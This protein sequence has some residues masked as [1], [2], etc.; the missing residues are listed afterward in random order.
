[1]AGLG[2]KEAMFYDVLEKST[3][4]CRLCYQLCTIP[5]GKRGLCGVR[6]NEGGRLYTLV[7][8]KAAATGLDPVE[9]KPLFHFHPGTS[10]YSI[11]TVGCNFRCRNCQNHDISQMPKNYGPIVGEDLQPEE[12]VKAAKRYE[13][14]SI[15][16]T[17]TE[18][19]VF[20][21]YAYE[22]ARLASE[23]GIRNIFVT[24]GYI[25][26]EAL[27]TIR[28]Y[29]DAANI[30][31]KSFSDEFYRES[32]GARL[33]PVLDNIKLHKELGIWIEITT[34]II[35][36]L[37]DSEE[38]L[39]KIARFIKDVG[40][41]IPWHVSQFYPMYQL[42][43][44]PRTPVSTLEMARKVGIEEG[45]RYVYEG[46][47]PG[48]EGENTYCYKCKQRLIRRFGYEI[49]E[50]NVKDSKCPKCGADVNGVGLA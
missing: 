46:N 31:L 24:N 15:A 1:V 25:S 50:N 43:H 35:P 27:K 2:R 40:E 39:R 9:K 6:V 14:K 47:V 36:T 17:Y 30:D 38:E 48:A 12:V 37:N 19:T 29:L 8:G 3:V 23:E 11:S 16:Y 4:K 34:L 7:Y 41:E 13:C 44:L 10:T 18:P 5:E 21:E 26:E 33:Q 49:L 22:T 28:L 45:L 32:C 20:F 42:L